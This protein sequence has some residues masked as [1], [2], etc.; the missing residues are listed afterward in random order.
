MQKGA[1]SAGWEDAN[2]KLLN[3]QNLQGRNVAQH[4]KFTTTP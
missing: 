2:E 3:E 1:I 4:S